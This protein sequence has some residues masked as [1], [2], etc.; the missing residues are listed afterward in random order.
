[1]SDG[2]SVV[3]PARHASVRLPG[4]PL[5]EIHGRPMIRWVCDVANASEAE[6]VIVATDDARIAEAVADFGG[7]CCL[8][9]ED[10]P[11]GTDRLLE[12]AE[13][14]GWPDDHVVVNLQGD[15]PLMDARN[16]TQVARNLLCSGCDMAT[17]FID[18]DAAEAADPN[19]VKLV[20]DARGHALY[21]SRAPIPFDREGDSG[22]RYCGHIGLYAYR[23]GFLRRFAALPPSP[24]ER[25]E[26]LE[27]LRALHHGFAIHVERALVRPGP[28]VDT[29][30]DLEQVRRL[31]EPP[32]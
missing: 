27:Q 18:L 11:S 3:I 19:R 13:Q 28:G 24:L 31:L 29:P 23:V 20:H 6:R 5:I 8:T 22:D 7:H 10:H 12:V 16:L 4:K 14:L 25:R 21:F 32:A 1:V 17:L 9:R 26:R 2:F 30:E 15:E